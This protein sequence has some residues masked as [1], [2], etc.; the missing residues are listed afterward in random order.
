MTPDVGLVA[1]ATVA[2]SLKAIGTVL[3][4]NACA[5]IYLLTSLPFH[6]YW[7]MYGLF[8][9]IFMS[10][11]ES[12]NRVFGTKVSLDYDSRYLLAFSVGVIVPLLLQLKFRRIQV[13]NTI[14]E[15]S[16]AD[17]IFPF[18][19]N[20]LNAIEYRIDIEVAE[21]LRPY[22]DQYVDIVLVRK[23]I[24]AHVPNSISDRGAFK[25]EIDS[26]STPV[27]AMAIYLRVSG[28]TAFKRVFALRRVP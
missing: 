9:G 14:V 11:I 15:I 19:H 2:A 4:A 20:L 17:V 7:V 1:V 3:K 6:L 28:K 24:L 5:G 18:E 10:A 8:G 26:A 21:F 25:R 16:L 23:R 12:L 27:E 13:G 22:E